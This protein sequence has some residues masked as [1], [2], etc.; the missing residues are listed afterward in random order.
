MDEAS[1]F[2]APWVLLHART[3]PQPD[4]EAWRAAV[5]SA[6]AASSPGWR[7][8]VTL[9]GED[10]EATAGKPPD[11]RGWSE[12]LSSRYCGMVVP[13]V[14]S[15][16]GRFY[17]GR[18]TVDILEFAAG[19]PEPPHRL[20][21][22]PGAG[23]FHEIRA[24]V[25]NWVLNER[26]W[27]AWSRVEVVA[28]PPVSRPA[29]PGQRPATPAGRPGVRAA[30]PPVAADDASEF[31]EQCAD[32]IDYAREVLEDKRGDAAAEFLGG[33]TEKLES[34]SA[35]AQERGFATDRMAAAVENIRAGVAKWDR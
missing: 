32:V 23:S 25:P 26:P 17:L 30:P 34:M 15:T 28:P 4:R 31:I 6:L 3:T 21:W 33:I 14:P 7:V 24:L 2:H 18:A 11:W 1:D 16:D 22:H 13:L 29:A 12:S 19:L 8:T 9:A 5:S 20:A 27:V 35:F 10:F